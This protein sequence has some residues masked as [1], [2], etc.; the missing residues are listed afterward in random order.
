MDMVVCVWVNNGANVPIISLIAVQM[1]AF[2]LMGWWGVILEYRDF[3][4]RQRTRP[5]ITRE[6]SK[7]KIRNRTDRGRL[8]RAEHREDNAEEGQVNYCRAHAGQDSRQ[9]YS[10]KGKRRGQER[11]GIT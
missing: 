2:S 8:G 10:G 9:L 6:I 1:I 11:I 3:I 7:I 4:C 5:T